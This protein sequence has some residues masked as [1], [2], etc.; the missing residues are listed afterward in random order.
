MPAHLRP[1]VVGSG[2]DVAHVDGAHGTVVG[3]F[4]H[5]CYVQVG[6]EVYAIAGPAV[7]PGPIHLIVAAPPAR[8][9]EGLAVWRDGARLRSSHWQ[10]ELGEA[11]F[12]APWR[13]G[14]AD[15]H[16]AAAALG[17]MLESLAVPA[18]LEPRWH[19]VR[20]AVAAGD[21]VASRELLEG[22][23]G[24]LTPTGDDVLAGLLLVHAWRGE[25]EDTLLRVA[26][27]TATTNLSRSFLTW[28]A[29]GQSVAPVHDLVASAAGHDRPAFDRAVGT[30][31]AI[32]GS[33]GTALLWGI[34]L[35]TAA[36]VNLVRPAGVPPA[37]SSA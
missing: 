24:G 13:P 21:L 9:T 18:D 4:R 20:R 22:R 10:V 1:L 31:S 30:V 7:A 27:D 17:S 19:S 28:A 6:G 2:V 12:F 8:V 3:T 25:D 16:H 11:A 15:L 29:R 23:G 32:G 14:R 37:R 33:S 5:G 34:G 35:A 36:S 26:R